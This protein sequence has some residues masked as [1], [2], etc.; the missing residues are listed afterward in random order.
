[1]IWKVAT[2]HQSASLRSLAIHPPGHRSL[3][4]VLLAGRSQLRFRCAGVVF[5][6]FFVVGIC[7][8][9]DPERG[10]VSVCAARWYV[11]GRFCQMIGQFLRLSPSTG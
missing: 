4:Y 2:Q 8:L 3:I 7:P 5:L 9:S 11:R 1:M 10:A 6:E